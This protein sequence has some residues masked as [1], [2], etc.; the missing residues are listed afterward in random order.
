MVHLRALEAVDSET[1][2]GDL[3]GKAVRIITGAEDTRDAWQKLIQP[4]D[5][6]GIKCN[7]VGRKELGTTDQFVTQLVKTLGR[8]GFDPQQIV[9]I[10]T[11]DN[12]VRRLKTRPRQFGWLPKEVLFASGK[13]QLAAVLEQVTAIINVPF[14]KTHNIAGVTG[15]LKNLSHAMIRRPGLYHDNGCMPYIGDIVALPQI[16]SKLRLHLVNA[17]RAV[18]QHGPCVRSD[19]WWTHGGL[20]AGTDPVAVDAV[21]V[22]VINT[23]REVAGLPPIGRGGYQIPYLHDAADKGL[24]TDDQDFIELIAPR[25]VF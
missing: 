15:C 20:L 12:L 10:E 8:A 17:M 25:Q 6:I 14:L 22:D 3:L 11:S 21:G 16:R 23:Q 7:Q 5:V 1:L 18:F 13:E 4:D 19:S 24:G 2:L 9:L